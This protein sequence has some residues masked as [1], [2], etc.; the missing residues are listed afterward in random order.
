MSMNR[1]SQPPGDSFQGDQRNDGSPNPLYLATSQ[2]EHSSLSRH[3]KP[4]LAE[5][6]A[7]RGVG[8]T[9]NQDEHRP[10]QE[11]DKRHDHRTHHQQQ[12]QTSSR[13]NTL[14]PECTVTLDRPDTQTWDRHAAGRTP[15][16]SPGRVIAPPPATVTGVLEEPPSKSANLSEE[17]PPPAA[18]AMQ[19]RTI[20]LSLG[21]ST[22]LPREPRMIPAVNC[23]EKIVL[24]LDVS[25]EM[26][27]LSFRMRNGD[28]VFFITLIKKALAIFFRTKHM[29]N[30]KH[31]FALMFLDT[32]SAWMFDF[33]SDPMKILTILEDMTKL[34]EC[35]QCE[36]SSIFDEILK[37]VAIPSASSGVPPYTVRVILIYGRS[38]CVPQ[39]NRKQNHKAVELSNCFGIDVV[40]VH[41][42]PSAENNCEKIFDV[43]CDLDERGTSYILEASK[44]PTKVFDCMAQLLAHPLQRCLQQDLNYCLE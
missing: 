22:D 2:S 27:S 25:K 43:L 7:S 29:M 38:V 1:H 15:I 6:S 11:R 3:S 12:P 21:A 40:Y 13:Y 5:I 44:N 23:P 9:G 36:L 32:S 41:D 42:P 16:G 28:K 35:E 8:N 37:H 24:C 20:R 14:G 10:H 18:K 26:E 30:S 34:V 33:C 4:T 17:K 19:A 39:L 31:E